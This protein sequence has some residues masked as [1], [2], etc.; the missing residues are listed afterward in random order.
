M[1]KPIM[2]ICDDDP[3]RVIK[4]TNTVESIPEVER[5]DVRPVSGGELAGEIETL[6]IRREKA[7]NGHAEE[8]INGLVSIFDE[9]ELVLIDY[10]LTPSMA[11][12]NTGNPESRSV[13]EK[14]RNRSGES[15]AYLARC[16]SMA[17]FLVIVNQRF[18][19]ST[20]DVTMQR[21]ADSY[22]DLNVSQADLGNPALWAGRNTDVDEFHPWS[23]PV[24]SE[25]DQL[26]SK[27][28]AATDLEATLLDK[29]GLDEKSFDPRQLDLLGELDRQ[30]R[31]QQPVEITFDGLVESSMG[32]DAKDKQP[33]QENRRAIAASVVSRWLEQFVLPGQ[34]VIADLPHLVARFPQIL[35]DPADPEVWARTAT[36]IADTSDLPPTLQA[37]QR[38][39]EAFLSR[40]AWSVS[41]IRAAASRRTIPDE[42]PTLVFCEDTSR[43]V[44]LSKAQEVETDVPGPHTRRFIEHV[45]DVRYDPLRRV[46]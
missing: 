45:Q 35:D 37:G 31:Q 34:N 24:L 7:R 19:Q 11:M 42:W 38:A 2:L 10:D 33:S 32:L 22:A 20:F 29:L 6:N 26:W 36:K 39:A 43:F 25:V 41:D 40:S 44:P 13:L 18:Q 16:Y 12:A 8:E 23:W 1:T 3:K 30:G 5:F 14:L 4:W 46:L 17:G 21:F 28:V 9:A 15:V 27:R